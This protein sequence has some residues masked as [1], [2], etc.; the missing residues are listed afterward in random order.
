ML[1]LRTAI[2]RRANQLALTDTVRQSDSTC[3]VFPVAF[4]T[5]ADCAMPPKAVLE[6]RG[7]I[8]FGRIDQLVW[9]TP[10]S[11]YL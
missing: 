1:D 3:R 7:G 4:Q 8:L 6:A 10:L 11:R 2:D 9:Q 5:V